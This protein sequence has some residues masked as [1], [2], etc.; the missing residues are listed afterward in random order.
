MTDK[1]TDA[2]RTIASRYSYQNVAFFLNEFATPKS[3]FDSLVAN[4]VTG[5]KTLGHT[6]GNDTVDVYKRMTHFCMDLPK[7]K[8][9]EFAALVGKIVEHTSSDE[10]RDPRNL[11]C[12]P[13]N[14]A[15]LRSRIFEGNRAIIPNM[16]QPTPEVIGDHS[17]VSL[18]ACLNDLFLH[19]FEIDTITEAKDGCT[20]R[21]GTSRRAAELKAEAAMHNAVPIWLIPWSD[22]FEPNYST[23]SN[24]GSVWI[25]TVTIS[26][27]PQLLNAGSHTY[28][29]ALGPKSSSHD[30]IERKFQLELETLA[31]G[32]LVLYLSRQKKFKKVFGR[33]LV[34]L[35]DQP[36]RRSRLLLMQGNSR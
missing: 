16:P 11:D 33:V 12:L 8:R 31:S 28:V 35:H 30:E 23:K 7:S 27:P 6:L 2:I 17:Y 20:S 26:A 3:G 34:S 19:G 9:D 36:E 25:K 29:I 10:Q 18:I 1:E 5:Y 13:T 32:N 15:L 4:S 22:D 21:I 14:P 24:R